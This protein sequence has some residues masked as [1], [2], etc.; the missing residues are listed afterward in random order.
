MRRSFPYLL[1]NQWQVS[2]V[3]NFF[4]N[5]F[6][7][8]RMKNFLSYKF[9][10]RLCDFILASFLIVF[11]IPIFFLIALLIKASSR[12]P[13]LFKQKR[14]GKNK[15]PFSCYKFRTM[16]PEAD[17]MLKKLLETDEDI[18]IE[19]KYKQKLSKDPRITSIG[20]YLR[21]TSL[22]EIPQI[23]NVLKGDMSFIGPRPIIHEEIKRYEDKFEKAFSVYPGMSGLWQVSGR[24]N[25]SY[26][27]RVQLDVIYAKNLN[28]RLDLN[29]FFRTLGVMLL[30]FDRGAF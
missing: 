21:F 25:L 6:Y 2:K 23:I 19:F 16:H 3:M 8:A 20:K 7:K 17:F 22:D 15:K 30:P 27:R 26:G 13:V 29:I 18:Q 12:G 4:L 14:I 1:I 24:N 28:F 11:L 9:F 5:K 10:K